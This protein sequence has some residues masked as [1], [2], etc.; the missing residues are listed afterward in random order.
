MCSRVLSGVPQGSALSPWIYLFCLASVVQCNYTSRDKTK[1]QVKEE[2]KFLN[3][4]TPK[5]KEV[6]SFFCEFANF[7]FIYFY[8]KGHASFCGGD[9]QVEERS[10]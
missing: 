2:G 4:V 7:P 6:L 5:T 9:T 1:V 10:V 3:C 8:D